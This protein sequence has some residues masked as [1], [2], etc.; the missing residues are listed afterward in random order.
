[1]Y[2]PIKLYMYARVPFGPF[3]PPDL[4][5]AS[6]VSPRPKASS[7]RW[8]STGS[9][10]IH[11]STATGCTCDQPDGLTIISLLTLPI[12]TRN[13]H[14]PSLTI[15]ALTLS[16]LNTHLTNNHQ[17]SWEVS[18][19]RFHQGTVGPASRD[20][21]ASTPLP[22]TSATCRLSSGFHRSMWI[23]PNQNRTW[24]CFDF[25]KLLIEN[26]VQRKVTIRVAI[27]LY[28]SPPVR[29]KI[30]TYPSRAAPQNIS[31]PR[32]DLSRVPEVSPRN[33]VSFPFQHG[34][35]LGCIIICRQPHVVT[36]RDWG[37]P[38]FA[39]SIR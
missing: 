3:S 2:L 29:E 11:W 15:V 6:G 31:L 14:Q 37:S 33:T 24:H 28:V 8:G 19:F 5:L 18:F 22:N 13:C 32:N 34:Q 27:L 7:R 23:H 21:R 26:W 4:A 20:S 35:D 36:N 17:L 16:I 10:N 25:R 12:V 1:M 39:A 9:E 38:C 30:S